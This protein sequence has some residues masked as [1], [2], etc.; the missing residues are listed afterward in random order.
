ML[1]TW[2]AE[3][4]EAFDRGRKAFAGVDPK[5]AAL[6]PIP[7]TGIAK[8]T[9]E[10]LGRRAGAFEA[11][12]GEPG[13]TYADE[14]RRRFFPSLDKQ[15]WAKVVLASAVRASPTEWDE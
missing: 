7:P 9:A 8:E 5:D 15:G 11:T 10:E 1:E 3:L 14:A 13:K 4:R 12:H 6:D 2:V